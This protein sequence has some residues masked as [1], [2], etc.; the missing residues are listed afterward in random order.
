M[1][2][3]NR[4]HKK[5]A[6]APMNVKKSGAKNGKSAPAMKSRSPPLQK[7]SAGK[8]KKSGAGQEHFS[9]CACPGCFNLV[10]RRQKYCSLVRSA[11]ASSSGA[12]NCPSPDYTGNG[13]NNPTTPSAPTCENYHK[14]TYLTTTI[15]HRAVCPKTNVKGHTRWSR[16]GTRHW[17]SSCSRKIGRAY[18]VSTPMT[19]A[20]QLF[21]APGM[22]SRQDLETYLVSK[23]LY[24]AEQLSKMSDKKLAKT[25]NEQSRSVSSSNLPRF[26]NEIA[27][28]KEQMLHKPTTTRPRAASVV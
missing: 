4:A 21:P 8:N 1:G 9:Y 18:T 25:V 11:T 27:D 2:R 16:K 28:T 7:G 22:R 3:A 17:V 24:S 12:S 20:G 26:G 19:I 23:N 5:H 10:P 14:K 6:R 15:T 13:I